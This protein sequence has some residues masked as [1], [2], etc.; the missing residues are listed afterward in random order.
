MH[1]CAH[2]CRSGAYTRNFFLLERAL[3]TDYDCSAFFVFFFFKA[4]SI[5]PTMTVIPGS[6]E[7]YNYSILKYARKYKQ[8]SI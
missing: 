4:E 1:V 6:T 2:V 7:E 8:E 5:R 3:K